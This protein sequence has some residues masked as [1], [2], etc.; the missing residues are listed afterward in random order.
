MTKKKTQAASGIQGFSVDI[1]MVKAYH[2]M[3]KEKKELYLSMKYSDDGKKAVLDEKGPAKSKT[4]KTYA[5]KSI[6]FLLK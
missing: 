6:R 1:E 2:A 4:A 3:N 5:D